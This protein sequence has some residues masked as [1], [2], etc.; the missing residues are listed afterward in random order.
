MPQPPDPNAPPESIIVRVFSG[1]RNTV[2]RERLGPNDLEKAVNVDV[3]DAGQLRRRRGQ[4]RV[5]TGAWHSVRGP[6]AGKTYGVQD[7]ALG[8]VRDDFTFH[9][10]GILIGLNSP[11]CYTEVDGEVYFSSTNMAGVISVNELVNPWGHTD[12]QGNWLSPVY[13]PTDTLGE[14]GGT[15]LGDPPIAS[16]IEAYKGRIYLAVGKTLW[17]TEL[18]RYH[19]V[20]RTKNFMQFEHDITLVMA[21][22]DGLYVGTTGGMYFL[23]GHF[24][25]FR[26]Q[27]LTTAAVLPGSGVVVPTELVHPQGIQAPIPTGTAVVC[28]T[29][30]GVLAGFDSGQTFNLTNTRVAFPEGISAAGLYRSDSGANH[31]VAAVDSAGEPAANARIGDYIDAEIRRFQGG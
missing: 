18:Y 13:T 26:L 21:V 30:D 17:A 16:Q 20:D 3:D 29:N 7:G 2:T 19:Y 31:Y 28:L 22:G 5:R 11:V 14:V 12:G 24:G 1:I 4:T 23:Q 6:L 15:L 27:Q 8:I 9:P 10:L 25:A